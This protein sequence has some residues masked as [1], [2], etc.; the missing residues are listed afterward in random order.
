MLCKINLIDLTKESLFNC[1]V[2]YKIIDKVGHIK[3][4]R[5]Y[6]IKFC[7]DS[8]CVLTRAEVYQQKDYDNLIKINLYNCYIDLYKSVEINILQL[9]NKSK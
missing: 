7:M 2:E 4:N 3:N 1:L 9:S 6:Y 8:I 5:H